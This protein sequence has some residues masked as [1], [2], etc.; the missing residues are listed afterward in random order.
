[1]GI[2]FLKTD[3]YKLT[4]LGRFNWQKHT[5]V[6]NWIQINWVVTIKCLQPQMCVTCK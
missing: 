6:S 3:D 1:M 5:A 4:E 2:C